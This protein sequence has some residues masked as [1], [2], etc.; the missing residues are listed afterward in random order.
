MSEQRTYWG[1]LCRTCREPVAF[2]APPYNKSGLGKAHVRPGA[3]RCGHGHNHIY[4]PRDFRFFSS[5]AP[6]AEET[7]RENRSAYVAINS[8][9]QF[10]YGYE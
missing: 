7:M 10:S 1:I 3:I 5:A 2:D 8:S 9:P 6:I 4:F